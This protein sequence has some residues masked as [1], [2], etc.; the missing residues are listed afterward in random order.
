MSVSLFP[1][2]IIALFIVI[3][4]SLYVSVVIGEIFR[5]NPDFVMYL[6]ITGNIMVKYEHDFYPNNW[7]LYALGCS[8]L[9]GGMMTICLAVKNGIY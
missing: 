9:L 4:N 8:F 5:Y 6:F 7:M 3:V 2:M 1:E